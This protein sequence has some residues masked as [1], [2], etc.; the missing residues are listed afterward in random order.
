MA[1]SEDQ[2]KIGVVL[3]RIKIKDE[4][5]ISEIVIYKKVNKK[6]ETEKLRDF[7]FK[8]ACIQFSFK[9]DDSNML[10]FFTKTEVFEFD[11][12]NEGR[13]RNCKYQLENKLDDQPK[14]GVFNSDQTKFIVTS[15]MDILY[16]DIERQIEIDIDD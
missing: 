14:F 3:G 6:F 13:P 9:Y 4:Q 2:T 10:L 8:D 1:V 7:E 5:E 11:Y 12:L 16:V 15:S